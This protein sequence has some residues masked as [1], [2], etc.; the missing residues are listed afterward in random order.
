MTWRAVFDEISVM[1]IIM[2]AVSHVTLSHMDSSLNVQ[3]FDFFALANHLF[4]VSVYRATLSLRKLCRPSRLFSLLGQ[5]HILNWRNTTKLYRLTNIYH[6]HQTVTI[7]QQLPITSP[8]F[9]G[10]VLIS[11]FVAPRIATQRSAFCLTWRP[12]CTEKGEFN[13]TLNWYQM[14]SQLSE[15]HCCNYHLI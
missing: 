6:F 3:P 5:Q 4:P 8:S 11:L 9:Y 7:T 14:H 15:R 12:P 10:V 1:I 13:D 2:I